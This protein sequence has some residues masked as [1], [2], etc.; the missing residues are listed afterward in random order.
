MIIYNSYGGQMSTGFGSCRHRERSG[1]KR[2]ILSGPRGSALSGSSQKMHGQALA[3][4]YG[5][6][7]AIQELTAELALRSYERGV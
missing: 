1:N 5:L 7:F 2:I 3:G 6:S 4:Y